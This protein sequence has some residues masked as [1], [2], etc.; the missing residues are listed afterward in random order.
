MKI[1]GLTATPFR[2]AKEEQGLL[3]KIFKDGI[4]LSGNTVKGDLGI[5]YQ[6]GLKDLIGS[7]ILSKPIFECKYTEEDFG[8][9]LGLNA[10]ESIQRLDV[11]PDELAE[12]I[13]S[14]AA[15][16][17]LIV[18][19]YI[20]N[21]NEYGQTIVFAVNIWHAIALSKLFTKAGIKSDYI[22]SSIKDKITGVTLSREDNER[23]LQ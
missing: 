1:L 16:N 15:R 14:N 22:V 10:L 11:L 21:K 17:K 9:N 23:K 19:T 18:N 20:E 6:I 7:R 8:V 3:A 12:E 13:A 5:T 2:T 4:D